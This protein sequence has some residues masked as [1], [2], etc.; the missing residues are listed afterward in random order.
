MEDEDHH[1]TS[2]QVCLYHLNKRDFMK[3]SASKS[4]TNDSLKYYRRY[5]NPKAN[6]LHP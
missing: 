3:M 5:F 6:Q 4:A 1:G 2:Q